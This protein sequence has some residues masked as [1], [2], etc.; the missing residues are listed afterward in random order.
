[1]KQDVRQ[2]ACEEALTSSHILRHTHSK[3]MDGGGGA[4]SRCGAGGTEQS[5]LVLPVICFLAVGGSLCQEQFQ[6]E[7]K[8]ELLFTPTLRQPP[9]PHI[10]TQ[11]QRP[12]EVNE[13]QSVHIG[14]LYALL[15][16]PR[17]F[18]AA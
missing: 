4:T 9:P 7:A 13:H 2:K 11:T 10:H 14:C 18:P 16:A 8:E 15:V 12:S 6:Q 5:L 1:M 3:W 17:Q